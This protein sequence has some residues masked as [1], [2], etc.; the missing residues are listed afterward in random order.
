MTTI[1]YYKGTPQMQ[2]H[3]ISEDESVYNH[4]GVLNREEDKQALI[5]AYCGQG[6]A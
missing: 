5:S 3:L 1:E 2:K 6:Q 4:C